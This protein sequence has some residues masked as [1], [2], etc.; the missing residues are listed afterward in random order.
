MSNFCRRGVSMSAAVPREKPFVPL[1]RLRRLVAGMAAIL[2]VVGVGLLALFLLR[3]Y[4]SN[5]G[6]QFPGNDREH[7]H[8]ASVSS[9]PL[10]NGMRTI[11]VERCT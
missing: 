11:E 9:L 6:S 4:N 1:R 3:R 8:A 5:S 2:A 10:G 7:R